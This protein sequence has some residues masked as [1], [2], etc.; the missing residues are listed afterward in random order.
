M[1][2]I[3]NCPLLII[4]SD[5]L[6]EKDTV[7]Q[8]LKLNNSLQQPGMIASVTVQETGEINFPYF[9]CETIQASYPT[10]TLEKA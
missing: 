5:V 3:E 9:I 8:L 6:I 7:Y 10:T 4:E 1:E 2:Y